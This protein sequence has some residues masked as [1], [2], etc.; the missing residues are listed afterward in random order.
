MICTNSSRPDD[1]A[2][3]RSTHRLRVGGG[4]EL[5]IE[6]HGTRG[7][8]PTVVLH[9]GPGGGLTRSALDGFDMTKHDIV[10]FDQR[11]AGQS[12]PLADIRGNTTVDLIDDLEAIRALFGFDAWMVAGGS[13]GS[14]LGL[15]YA[16]AHPDR[17]LALRLHGI[18]LARPS[19]IRWWFHDVAHIFPDHW[20]PFAAHIPEDERDDL[21]QAYHTRLMSPN[22]EVARLAGWHLRNFSARTQT[23]GPDAAHVARLLESPEKYLPVARLFTHYCMNHAFLPKGALLAGIDGIR[24]IPAEILQGRYDMVTPMTSAW[25]LHQAWPEA[26]FEIVTCA[27]HTPSPDMLAAQRAAS[28]RLAERITTHVCN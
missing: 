3:E 23:F 8:I 21:L 12:T 25:T 20:A 14:C 9:G 1:N 11:G 27:N 28:D 6:R 13:W 22:L 26:R 19:E 4:H 7:T 16:Q 24:H 17:V 15:A 2:L 18:F 5:H 10:L